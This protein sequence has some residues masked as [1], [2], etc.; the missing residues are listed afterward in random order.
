VRILAISPSESGM[1]LVELMVTIM[2]VAILM[3][4][5][6]PSYRYVTNSNRATSEVNSLLADMQ[7]ARA[8]AIKEGQFVTVCPST[9]S[10]SCV[11]NSSIWNTGWIVF[12]DVNGNGIVDAGDTVLRVEKAFSVAGDS[13]ISDNNVSVL[14]FNREGFVSGLPSTPTGYITITLHTTPLQA[15]WTRCLQVMT[16]GALTTER[17]QQGSCN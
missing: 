8:E 16:L 5:G 13:F 10:T 15:Q 9:N 12:S 11:A 1:T 3:T 4:I 6:I 2:L 17:A 14:T 7:F